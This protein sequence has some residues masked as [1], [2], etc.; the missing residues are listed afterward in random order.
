MKCRPFKVGGGLFAPMLDQCTSEAG[1]DQSF[2]PNAITSPNSVENITF[3]NYLVQLLTSAAFQLAVTII[4]H[5]PI[6]T[7]N[8]IRRIILYSFRH[9]C[10]E[11]ILR[12]L[13]L[14]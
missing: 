6:V 7:H 2:T 8:F 13:P 12:V 3:T 9:L 14:P 1:M 4:L 5:S 10:A 11:A